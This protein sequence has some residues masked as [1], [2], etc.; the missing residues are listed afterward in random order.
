ML[1]GIASNELRRDMAFDRRDHAKP[2]CVDLGSRPSIDTCW[3]II[4]QFMWNAKGFA[5]TMPG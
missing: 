2:I 5:G 4:N 1:A 3:K